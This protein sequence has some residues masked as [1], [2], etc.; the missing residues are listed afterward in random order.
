MERKVT[1]QMTEKVLKK[2]P[3]FTQ[4]GKRII[5][6]WCLYAEHLIK[7]ER[8]KARKLPIVSK[9]TENDK[10]TFKAAYMKLKQQQ[11][12]SEEERRRQTERLAKTRSTNNSLKSENRSKKL[13]DDFVYCKIDYKANIKQEARREVEKA[14]VN[15]AN[16][17]REVEKANANSIET[18]STKPT[19]KIKPVVKIPPLK[20]KKWTPP[21]PPKRKPRPVVAIPPVKTRPWVPPCLKPPSPKVKPVIEYPP[22]K[23]R[24]M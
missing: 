19:L 7:K 2:E 17:K 23:M 12:K 14:N 15:K 21:S 3:K 11:A 22:L 13:D 16:I 4:D 1:I 6:N 10:K 24:K 18:P 9:I 8:L 5:E 20:R